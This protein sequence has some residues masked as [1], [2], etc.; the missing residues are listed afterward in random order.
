MKEPPP[1]RLSDWSPPGT[2]TKPPAVQ[3]PAAAPPP[4]APVIPPPAAPPAGAGTGRDLPASATPK[5]PAQENLPAPVLGADAAAFKSSPTIFQGFDLMRLPLGILRRW[6]IPLALGIVGAAAG[7]GLAATLLSVKATVSV[8]LMSRN[9]QSFAASTSSYTPARPQGATL[10]GA[11]SSPQ[12]AREVAAKFGG[13]V[14]PDELL[15]M[16][17][18]EEIRKT[19][20]VDILVT[21]PFD[22]ERTADLARLWGE[23]ALRFTS[24]LQSDESGETKAYLEEQLRNMSADLDK[25]NKETTAIREKAGVVDVE[26]EIDASLKTMA[27]LDLRYETV[28]TDLQAVDRQIASLRQEIRKHGPGYEELR[29][30]E[31]KLASLAEYYTEQNPV[32]QEAKDRVDK[33]REKMTQDAAGGGD[34]LSEFTG[35]QVS[36]AL[37]L[38]IMEAEAKRDNLTLQQ[39]QIQKMREAAQK[40]LKDLPQLQMQAAPLLERAQSLRTAQDALMKRIQEVGVFR[41]V[42][43]GYFRLFKV[44]AAKDVAVGSLGKKIVIMGVLGGVFFTVLGM[45]GAA[46]LEFMDATVRTPAEAQAALEARGLAQIP[47]PTPKAKTAV[48]ARRQDLWASVIGALSAGRMRAFWSPVFTPNAE[49]F[50]EA[51]LDAGRSMGIR[52]L[53]VHLSGDIAPLLGALPR[54]T[55]QQLQADADGDEPVVLLELPATLSPH[56]VKGIVEGIKGAAKTYPEIWIEASGHVHEPMASVLREFPE[57]V[58]L[59]ALGTADRNFWKTQRALLGVHRPLRG[60]V[61]IG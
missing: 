37:Y 4:P 17:T 21:T 33:L 52:V 20:F 13:G 29:S 3:P 27:E 38:Q 50:W 59:C 2:P 57:P 23:E 46:G 39:Q 24:K 61:S 48:L 58:V 10:L 55:M 25:V 41:E 9:P 60:V 15:E 44:P 43:P 49:L 26:K 31:N 18:I 40:K 6:Y 8:R 51:L 16:I 19:D 12:I 28:Q 34:T 53:V 5:N 35:T 11:L 47:R 1:L 30:E 7:A 54:I 56:R 45:L 22:A 32:Y 36:N 42:S 14:K